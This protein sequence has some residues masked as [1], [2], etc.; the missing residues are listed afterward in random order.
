MPKQ[1]NPGGCRCCYS[2]CDAPGMIC[3]TVNVSAGVVMPLQGATVTVTSQASPPT[4]EG[5]AT[6]A[7]DGTFCVTVPR[8]GAYTVVITGDCGT[9]TRTA[10]VACGQT[11]NLAAVTLPGAT[12]TVNITA[13]CAEVLPSTTIVVTGPGGFSRTTGTLPPQTSINIPVPKFGAYTVTVS[14][15]GGCYDPF[16]QN[17]DVSSCAVTVNAS[18]AA[19]TYNY[20]GV[21]KGCQS[22]GVA[23]ASVTVQGQTTTTAGDGSFALSIKPACP[24]PYTVSAERYATSTGNVTF[25]P[26]SD[27][28]GDVYQ[29]EPVGFTTPGSFVCI[30]RCTKPIGLSASVTD[31]QGTHA[32]T[33]QA[34]GGGFFSWSGVCIDGVIPRT[35]WCHYSG[36]CNPP[37]NPN[38]ATY[39]GF[40][41]YAY[42][43]DCRAAPGGGTRWTLGRTTGLCGSSGTYRMMDTFCDADGRR[44]LTQPIAA[45]G[46]PCNP[47][48]PPLPDGYGGLAGVQEIPVYVTELQ[49]IDY[50]DVCSPLE[51][52]AV[53]SFTQPWGE[54]V[55]VRLFTT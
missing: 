35:V 50:P 11:V 38:P 27:S 31:A 40:V 53:F 16:S 8:K 37:G 55:T 4:V 39:T 51:D 30:C 44:M 15:S 23:G 20:S 26:C 54:A 5:T 34:V 10:T 7:A 47:G 36:N 6:T 46:A 12:I 1:H 24:A 49:I 41:C 22:V 45:R 9:N 32:L 25:L 19:K 18:L 14:I 33:P 42:N 21:V 43:L 28:S 29:L 2:V 48:A 17:L 13:E 3:G 52:G